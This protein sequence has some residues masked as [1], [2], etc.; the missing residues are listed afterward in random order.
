M[1]KLTEKE[2][3]EITNRLQP[4]WKK[5]QIEYSRFLKKERKIEEEMNRNLKLKLEFFYVDGRCVGMGAEN[6]SDRKSFPLIHDS[7]LM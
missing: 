3:I 7:D 2:L 6:Y 5:R 4:F 1:E